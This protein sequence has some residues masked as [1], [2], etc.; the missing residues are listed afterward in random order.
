MNHYVGVFVYAATGRWRV[1]VPDLPSYEV[2]EGTLDRAIIRAEEFLR[3]VTRLGTSIPPPRPLAL[4][5]LDKEW[6]STRD[7]DWSRSVVAMIQVRA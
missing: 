1:L 4:I 6:A 2:E 3:Q 5:K 7:V